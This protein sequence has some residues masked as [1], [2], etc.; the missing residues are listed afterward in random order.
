MSKV[1]L[2]V[3]EINNHHHLRNKNKKT[4]FL[5]QIDIPKQHRERL[6]PIIK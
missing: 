5:Q 6:E 4:Q 2:V 1:L 3:L